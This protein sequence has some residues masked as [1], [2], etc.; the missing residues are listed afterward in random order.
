MST[1]DRCP[2]CMNVYWV[3]VGPA[4]LGFLPGWKLRGRELYVQM[5]QLE[6][7]PCQGLR[8]LSLE[9]GSG[10]LFQGSGYKDRQAMG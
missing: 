2:A 9:A 7:P 3:R 1:S 5:A 10:P 4:D 8:V 6:P